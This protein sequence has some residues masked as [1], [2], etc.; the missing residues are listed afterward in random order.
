MAF[1]T[2]NAFHEI[3]DYAGSANPQKA[4]L[5]MVLN[6]ITQ[7]IYER[8]NVSA[9]TNSDPITSTEYFAA[10]MTALESSSDS[11]QTEILKLLSIILP[12]TPVAVL[13]AKF[14]PSAQALMRILNP[15]SSK[16]QSEEVQTARLCSGTTCLGEILRSQE[17]TDSTWTRP[18]I[19]EALQVLIVFSMSDTSRPK[20][21]KAAR[22]SLSTLL[23]LHR[24]H[25]LQAISTHIAEF[26]THAMSSCT[27]SRDERKLLLL[28]NFLEPVL[29]LMTR[30][31]FSS[32]VAS[33]VKYVDSWIPMIQ[34]VTVKT[35]DAIARSDEAKWT[36]DSL[37][38]TLQALLNASNFSARDA[39]VGIIIIEL[40]D[41]M[42]SR[43][44]ALN[45]VQ[46]R[47]LVPRAIALL[48]SLAE[49]EKAHMRDRCMQGIYN[50]LAICIQSEEWS[51]FDGVA[52]VVASLSSLLLLRYQLAWNQVFRLFADLY[53]D[54]SNFCVGAFD[55]ILRKCA[56]LY[57]ASSNTPS[58]N[59]QQTDWKSRCGQVLS[60]AIGAG[61]PAHFL[62]VVSILDNEGI[63][64]KQKAWI[65]PILREGCKAF[66]CELSF[67]STII[68]GIARKCEAKS[69]MDSTSSLE[70]KHLQEL[71]MD[72]WRLFPSFCARAS[73]IPTGFKSI[74]KTLSN[75]LGDERYPALRLVVCQG[76]MS[77]LKLAGCFNGN[78]GYDGENMVEEEQLIDDLQKQT[79]NR[80][81][82]SNYASRF[83]TTLINLSAKIDP[84]D[85]NVTS[86][87]VQTIEG[88]ASLESSEAMDTRFKSIL[89]EFLQSIVHVKGTPTNAIPDEQSRKQCGHLMVITALVGS[90]S[91]DNIH[92]LYRAIKPSLLNDSDTIMQKHAYSV[93]VSICDH[94]PTFMQHENN[95]TDVTE[96]ITKSLL[97][98]SVPSK[99]M[100]LRCLTHLVHA[101]TQQR[102]N[103]A[104]KS[105]LESFHTD[106]KDELLPNLVGEIILCTKESNRRARETA[107]QL[108]LSL[109]DYMRATSTNGLD[110][111]IQIIFGGL[112]AK[113]PHMRSAAVLCLSRIVYEFGRSEMSIQKSMPQLLETVLMLLHEKANEVIKAVIGF[114]KLGIA[115]LSK[116]QLEP[117]LPAMVQGLLV[118][119]GKS[120]HRFRAK[121]RVILL[122]LVRKFGFDTLENVIPPEDRPLLRHMKKVKG[123]EERKKEAYRN[124]GQLDGS[125]DQFM[126][127]SEEED[128]VCSIVTQSQG[129]RVRNNGSGV[130]F[131]AKSGDIVDLLDPNAVLQRAEMDEQ[132]DSDDSVMHF[133][134]DGR[135][136]VP[137]ERVD[138]NHSEADEMK[139][140]LQGINKMDLNAGM[141]RN[142]SQEMDGVGQEY[143]AKK[144]RG[145]VRK[146][147]K[148][149][150]YAYIPLDPKL[151]ATRNRR[152][153]VKRFAANVG[154]RRGGK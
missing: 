152:K 135:L 100:R 19:L 51:S 40:V 136:I 119:I 102:R 96:T 123:R 78:G 108:L 112:A 109:A 113:T 128:D 111:Y 129:K 29:P 57:E 91:M 44:H 17:V 27:P 47:K 138:D 98:C 94:H 34:L 85:I 117:H 75:A 82:L 144:A 35:L 13:R 5:N 99:K 131:Q 58:G 42:V 18:D 116:R 11:H 45:E 66:P 64:F 12:Q 118:W 61:G 110:E 38:G 37:S 147:G 50:V 89:Q 133:A 101:L 134:K 28:I 71:T 22:R 63:V 70:S 127:L 115:I 33:L 81:A 36:Q 121:T 16:V 137:D 93:I 103:N 124:E 132:S 142:R 74:A 106:F 92:F 145:D 143:K 126:N 43:L 73:D 140:S 107:F 141:K 4:N 68:L 52:R 23:Q 1:T 72:L 30:S 65:V 9:T 31:T 83:L 97:A 24:E 154:R 90:V 48:C 49:S 60:S 56:E 122:K 76:L 153:G 20:V 120:K 41:C 6:V 151:M 21:R 15:D 3:L 104:T 32:L 53:K 77:L 59:D 139:E 146:K 14:A 39:E 105:A 87:L 114:M 67:F 55:E 69:R 79:Q 84:N 150:P 125:F 8:R 88:F 54:H 2:Q 130:A 25:K 26:V 7:V 149:E 95:L 148:L 10:L 80:K 86:C 62:S 46:A